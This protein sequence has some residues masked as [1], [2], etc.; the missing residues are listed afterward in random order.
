ML[1]GS[2]RR[3]SDGRSFVR[4]LCR[5]VFAVLCVLLIPAKTT[6]PQSTDRIVAFRSEINIAIDRTL[7]VRE[8]YEVQ[9]G[10]GAFDDGLRRRLRIKPA[11]P[12]RLRAGSV[13]SI[14][15]KVD[16]FDGVVQASQ[17]NDE[18]EIHVISQNGQWSRGT[19][20][21]ELRYIAKHQF[22]IYDD[23]EDLNQSISGVWQV[24]IEK[25]DVELVFPHGFPADSSISADTGTESNFKFDCIRTELPSSVKFETTHP[26]EPGKRLFI[27]GRFPKRGYFVS[28][29]KEDGWEAILENHPQAKPWVAF[30]AAAIVLMLLGFGVLKIPVARNADLSPHQV[31]ALVAVVATIFSGVSMAI[32]GE[33]YTGM[34][35]I[36]V[37]LLAAWMLQGLRNQWLAM[38]IPFVLGVGTNLAFYY[39]FA[40]SGRVLWLR[41]ADRGRTVNRAS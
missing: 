38:L 39:F 6:R 15:A 31:A 41:F 17:T 23:Y 19:H 32:F 18:I 7:T 24:P 37:G 25:A 27:S 1:T 16:G 35:G 20:S 30:L 9:N 28:N 5:G 26:L 40:I 4:A 12:N 29:V 33:F 34:P 36:G 8:N 21:V 3:R 22:T 13:E 2:T 10:A 11:G 14:T